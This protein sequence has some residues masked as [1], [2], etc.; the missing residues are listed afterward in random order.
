MSNAFTVSSTGADTPTCCLFNKDIGQVVAF[1]V[2]FI[3]L[4][5]SLGFCSVRLDLL[6]GQVF[7]SGILPAAGHGHVASQGLISPHMG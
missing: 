3:A 4:G 6:Y 7:E 1:E 2:S 5:L